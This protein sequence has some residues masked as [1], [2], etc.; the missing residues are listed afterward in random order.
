METEVKN[1]HAQVSFVGISAGTI[2]FTLTITLVYIPLDRNDLK[3]LKGDLKIVKSI[4]NLTISF[5]YEG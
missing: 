2:L 4:S 3:I 1:R 5:H